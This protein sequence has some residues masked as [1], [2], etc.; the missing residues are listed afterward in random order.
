MANK[1]LSMGSHLKPPVLFVG[2][3]SQWKKRMI[4]FLNLK[5]RDYMTSIIDGPGNPQSFVPGQAATATSPVIPDRYVSKPY[6]FFTDAEKARYK[7]DDEVLIYLTMAIPNGFYNRVDSRE[8]AKDLWDEL[9]K[10]FQGSKK[11]IQTK[12]NQSINAYEGF[13]AKEGETLLETYNRLN[14]ILNVLKRNGM[15]KSEL[16][17]NYK[18]IKNLNLEW[19]SYAINIQMTKDMAQEDVNDI[20]TTLSQHED[21]VKQLGAE[22][23]MVKNSLALMSE[24]NKGSSF[25]SSSSYKSKSRKSRALLT[26]VTDSST[27]NSSTES[28]EHS[29]EDMQRFAENLALLIKQFK[30]FGRNKYKPKYEIYKKDRYKPRSEKKYEKREEKR[31]E[32][33]EE[34][35][36]EKR[37]GKK[38]EIEPKY[39]QCYNCGKPGHFSK[40]CMFKCT[41]NSEYYARKTL[42]AKKVE[43]G[44]NLM[45]EEENWLY[46]SSDDES[47]HFTQVCM[48]AK[49]EEDIGSSSDHSDCGSEV[50]I[51]SLK[52]QVKFMKEEFKTLKG[53]LSH[54]R[55]T[56]LNFR[57]E[58]SMLKDVVKEKESEK[59]CLKKDKDVLNSKI[60][61]LEKDLVNL[62]AEKGKVVN[63]D[64][65]S[66]CAD[67][68]SSLKYVGFA[69]KELNE[70]YKT[71]KIEFS[72]F[73][74]LFSPCLPT[75]STKVEENNTESQC[76]FDESNLET[77]VEN[78]VLSSDLFTSYSSNGSGS[79][80]IMNQNLTSDFSKIMTEEIF[81]EMMNASVPVPII[82]KVESNSEASHTW[83]IDSGCSRHMTGFK[84]LLHNYVEESVG[85]VC[86]AIS[87]VTGYIRGHGSLTNDTVT[88]KRVLYVEGL[89]HNLFSTS[90]F[91]DSQFQVRFTDK[92]C[93]IEDKY[94]RAVFKAKRN[95]NLYSVN[96]PTL[97]TS[98][99]VCL[100]TK[101]SRA[102]SWIWHRRLSHQNFDAINQLARQGI[103]KGLPE[104]RFE[105][106]SLCP[107]CEMGKMKRTSHESKTQFSSS[108]PLELI[109]MDLC[110]PMRTQ[111]IN[112]KKYILVM[113]DEYSRYTWLEFLRNKSD[114]EELIIEFLKKIQNEKLQ[115]YLISVGI[116]HNFSAAYTTQQNGVV[117]RKNRTLVEAART[118]LSYSELPMFLWAEA[119]ATA[120]YILNDRD[121]F[122][123]FD[124][125]AD[126]GYF[127]GFSLTSKAY[128]I[129]NRRTKTIMESINVSF[130]ESSTLTS[131]HNS[132]ELKLKQ[133]VFIQDRIEPEVEQKKSSNSNKITA[134]LDLLFFD[135]FMDIC[136]DFEKS[137]I[138][139]S[140]SEVP[141]IIPDISG[142][143][144]NV[145]IST[146]SG[147]STRIHSEDTNVDS[148]HA[149][150][151]SATEVPS[152]SSIAPE[153]FTS[154][155]VVQD[156]P[157]TYGVDKDLPAVYDEYEEDNTQAEIHPI[158]STVKWIRDHPLHNIIGNAQSGVQTRAASANFCLYSS[159]L[160][161][162]EPKK[163]SEA[164]RDPDLILAMQDE[165]L[166]F[167][168]KK[169]W[170]LIPLP[171]GKSII[172]TKWVF[173]NKRDESGVVVRNKARL[174]AKGYCQQE[175]IDYDETFAPVARL[176]VIR[177]F[178]SYVA[179]K[180]FTV[181]QMDVKSAFLNGI[182]HEEVYVAQPEGFVDP[183]NPDHV[184]V[185]DKALYGVKHAPRAWYETLTQFL[186]AS[187][188]KKGTID[189]TLFLKKQESWNLVL[190]CQ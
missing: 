22:K 43:E 152:D 68:I 93:Y 47:A 28:E 138:S 158:P 90:Q 91:C 137:S 161:S 11:S 151:N 132:S 149:D 56:M 41:K 40:D 129:Y 42:L 82:E 122:G 133:K 117:E 69:Y 57:D 134:E 96:F 60:S 63:D 2:D 184:Y 6:Q 79:E 130:D 49:V 146:T 76:Q 170:R 61:E 182:L 176:E 98:R 71:R 48:M 12:L 44:Q 121:N 148:V 136:A 154:E 119:V 38:E 113:I 181:F 101:A 36:K 5:N 163:D 155:E 174:V 15:N 156:V 177:I 141:I 84:H 35:R 159:F 20:F 7:L 8:S 92:C 164:L 31:D 107:A 83:Y 171:E 46:K 29:D 21:E 58:N 78:Q 52:A 145:T 128:Q 19:K 72:E 116:S 77:D 142:P 64:D 45:A 18:F 39:G 3:Y 165:L 118:M 55:Q 126:E 37:E 13:H 94:G 150:S 66:C 30:S 89:D 99:P 162:L 143:S 97:S 86:Y 125:K 27:D 173:K 108:T 80:N 153:I 105:K 95:A 67:S 14:V 188:F 127:I 169:V 102:E 183:K 32:K 73:T 187:G 50:R 33:R 24:R 74:S 167:E 59:D 123:K 51:Q 16:E 172:G 34:K 10:Q 147:T 23:K 140:T 120:C 104:L 190:K 112:G 88:I 65:I 185:L 166:Q 178:L 53:K 175:G 157:S 1:F 160:S 168:R 9:E 106:N 17:I 87:E 115:S 131:E 70:S 124:K 144:E 110:G 62:N 81:T 186:L 179:H 114:V 100:I 135:A 103:V 75:E 54:E 111:S 180:N 139:A 109:H 85:T 25:K 189:T 26:E 4:Q